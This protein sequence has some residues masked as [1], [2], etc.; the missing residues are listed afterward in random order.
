MPSQVLEIS[1]NVRGVHF[2]NGY[3]EALRTNGSLVELIRP[4]TETA[5]FVHLGPI[6][7]RGTWVGPFRILNDGFLFTPVPVRP[8][9][10]TS[11]DELI[12][13]HDFLCDIPISLPRKG[14]RRNTW[15]GKL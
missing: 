9:M 5:F 14:C 8:W 11:I 6:P 2:I 15:P 4:F 1:K 13:I 12:R 3:C 10:Y 7:C